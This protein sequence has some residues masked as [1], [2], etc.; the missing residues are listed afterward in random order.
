M[1]G[2][3]GATVH[4]DCERRIRFTLA[5]IKEIQKRYDVDLVAGEKFEFGDLDDIVWIVWTGLRHAG[6]TPDVE[7]S[8]WDRLLIGLGLRE[9]PRLTQEIVAE[10]IDMENFVEVTN[11]LKRAMGEEGSVRSEIKAVEVDPTEKGPEQEEAKSA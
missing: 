5:A 6:E 2:G 11:V 3:R 4:L 10:W 9:E 8:W 1:S 7:L